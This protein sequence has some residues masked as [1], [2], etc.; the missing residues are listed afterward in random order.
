MVEHTQGLSTVTW[1]KPEN[2]QDSPATGGMVQRRLTGMETSIRQLGCL[3]LFAAEVMA[4]AADDASK[5]QNWRYPNSSFSGNS[6]KPDSE[7]GY[8][9]VKD[10]L[11]S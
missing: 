8:G 4:G 9:T 5:S 1:Q 7:L 3:V 2:G 11:L 10:R 6:S